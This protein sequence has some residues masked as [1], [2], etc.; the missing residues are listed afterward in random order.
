MKAKKEI[1]LVVAFMI[2]I[3][4]KSFA[5][6][7]NT[8]ASP[9]PAWPGEDNETYYV[10]NISKAI[11]YPEF[12]KS[13]GLEGFV[14]V[15]YHITQFGEIKVDAINGSNNELMNYVY[16][17]LSDLNVN[18]GTSKYQYAKFVFKLY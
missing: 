18:S 9:L 8:T 7:I 5:A 12:A 17:Q 14:L 13:E 11:S 4:D 3:M 1:V 10:E 15:Q 16:K 6:S 2:F